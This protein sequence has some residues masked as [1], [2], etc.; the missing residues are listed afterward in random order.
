MTLV[1]ND[2]HLN[3]SG[4]WNAR[5]LGGLPT[6]SGRETAGPPSSVPTHSTV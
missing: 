1:R 4:C 3:S 5:D 2:R 6:A